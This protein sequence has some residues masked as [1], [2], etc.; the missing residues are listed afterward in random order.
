MLTAV[1]V[2]RVVSMRRRGL[3]LQGLLLLFASLAFDG[4][5]GP[6]QDRTLKR[7]GYCL[8]ALCPGHTYASPAQFRSSSAL[9]TRA[10]RVDER[11]VSRYAGYRCASQCSL[12]LLHCV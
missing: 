9:A 10:Y 5:T 7:C 6:L 8:V 3:R 2:C 1:Y 12:V 4:C 11:L